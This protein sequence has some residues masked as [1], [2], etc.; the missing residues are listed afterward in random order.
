MLTHMG[1]GLLE[2]SVGLA[3]CSQFDAR[4][5]VPIATAPPD[6]EQPKPEHV[7]EP[8]VKEEEAMVT[9]LL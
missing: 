2:D 9:R 5:D 1:G 8:K 6:A 7:T 3:T 4:Y